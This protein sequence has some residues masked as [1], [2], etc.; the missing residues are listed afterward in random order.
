MGLHVFEDEALG[1]MDKI[2]GVIDSCKGDG[3]Y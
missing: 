2:A 3:K 1:G